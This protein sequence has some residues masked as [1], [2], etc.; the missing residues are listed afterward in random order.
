MKTAIEL[1]MAFF[2][3]GAVLFG[4]GYSMLPH[5]EREVVER[6]KWATQEEILDYFAIGQCTPGIIAVNVATMVGYRNGGVLGAAFATLGIV[7]PSLIIITVIA[8]FLS[9][10]THIPAVIHAFNG[11]RVAVAALISTAVIKLMKSN[12]IQKRTEGE[13][14][15][16][17]LIKNLP[18]ILLCVL[19]F[20]LVA[21][22]NLS[23][24]YAV[25]GAAIA[26]ILL[27]KKRGES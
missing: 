18:S 9:N 7:T 5:L 13:S 23:P 8:S 26:G 10:F 11:I 25:V 12:V 22:A 6:H 24:I 4:G 16:G 19:A 1:F 14:T 3:I 17:M 27:Y 20:V 2:R 15:K 21:V